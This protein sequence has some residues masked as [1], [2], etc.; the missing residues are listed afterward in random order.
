MVITSYQAIAALSLIL[1]VS[2]GFSQLSRKTN[3]PSVLMLILLGVGLQF[4]LASLN[5]KFGPQIQNVLELLGTVGLIM[6]VLEAA[7][8]LELSRDKLGLILQSAGVALVALLATS[9]LM[10]WMFVEVFSTSWYSAL[11]FSVPLSV[12]SSAIIIPSVVNFA[13]A[14]RE[15]M[16]YESTFSD[17]LGIIVFYFLTTT[18]PGSSTAEVA[19]AVSK[20]LGITLAIAV[21]S[22]YALVLMLI[23]L[24]TQVKLF[25]LIALLMLIYASGKML[26][27]SSLIIILLFGLIFSN[28]RIFFIGRLRRLVKSEDMHSILHSFH[29]I[30]LESAFVVRTF[31]FVVFGLT[32]NLGLLVDPETAFITAAVGLG[33][34]GAIFIVRLLCLKLFAYPHTNPEGWIAPRGLITILLFSQIPKEVT[35]SGFNNGVL[36]YAILITGLIMTIAMIASARRKRTIPPGELPSLAQI[37]AMIDRRLGASSKSKG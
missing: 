7:L 8:D 27:I 14:R 28:H 26:H 9:A 19:W 5:I 2:F 30:T 12:M 15:F 10:G 24:R 37:D 34:A 4:G 22:S 23:N 35:I 17:I 3:I 13:P 1:I 11:V 16:V 6:I 33:V 25:L 36:L 31:F 21:V 18:E 29:T 20:N 32:L